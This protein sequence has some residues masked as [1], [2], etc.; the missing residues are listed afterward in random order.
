MTYINPQNTSAY[1]FLKSLGANFHKEDV[2]IYMYNSNDESEVIAVNTRLVVDLTMN[3]Q[4]VGSTRFH[5]LLKSHGLLWSQQLKKA[6]LGE[7]K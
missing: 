2:E 3:G 5:K 6:R 7:H 4:K 1:D